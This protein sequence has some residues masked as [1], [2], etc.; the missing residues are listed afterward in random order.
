VKKSQPNLQEIS[1]AK[2]KLSTTPPTANGLS[3]VNNNC[4]HYPFQT[5]PWSSLSTWANAAIEGDQVIVWNDNISNPL[6]VGYAWAD[7][8]EGANL[9]NK[10]G[11]AASSFRTD[12]P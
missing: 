1:C 12:K 10:E 9:Y 6:Y 2:W 4:R 11:L 8:P 5:L 7:N 3:Y